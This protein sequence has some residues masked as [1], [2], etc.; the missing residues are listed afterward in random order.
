[1]KK[2]AVNSGLERITAR[3]LDRA[4]PAFLLH[5][6]LGLRLG[7]AVAGFGFTSLVFF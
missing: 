6:R 1:M 2:A 5:R 7:F 3:P 4:R